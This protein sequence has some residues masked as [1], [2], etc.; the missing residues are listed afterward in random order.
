M[1]ET[2]PLMAGLKETVF[3]LIFLDIGMVE[4]VMGVEPS[5]PGLMSGPLAEQ[6][7]GQ[8]LLAASDPILET[9]LFFWKRDQGMAEVDYLFPYKNKVFPIEVKAGKWGKL[10]SLHQFVEH[11]KVPFGIKI[12]QEPLGWNRA[13]LTVPFYLTSHLSRLID[14]F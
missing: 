4:Q 9:K 3:K 13:V 1:Y 8:E 2:T 10:K 7:V 6:F 14:S 11:S 5:D 12:S